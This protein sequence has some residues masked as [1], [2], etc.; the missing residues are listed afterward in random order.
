MTMSASTIL[1]VMCG[2]F[3]L[4]IAISALVGRK[5]GKQ[6]FYN[7]DRKS[8][9]Y[10][11][12]FGMIGATLS[13]VTF[14]SVPGEVG[15]SAFHYLQFVLGNF[16]GYLIIAFMLLPFYYRHNLVSIY[17][18]LQVK[19][20]HQG[21]MTTSG[22]FILSK[23]IGAGFRLYL[24]AIVLQMAIFEQIGMSFEINVMICLLVIW[25]YTYRTGIKA[26]VWSDSLQTIILIFAVGFSI[27]SIF[28]GT[29]MN[30]VEWISCLKKMPQTKVFE[31]DWH[32]PN[33][34]FKQFAAGIFIT[35]AINGFDQ[36]IIQKNLTCRNITQARKNMIWFSLGFVVVVFLFLILGAMLYKYSSL[37]SIAVP[38]QSDQVFPFLAL[39]HLGS[40]M[41]L[42]FVLGVTAAAFSSADSATTALTT[43]FC[44]DFLKIEKK[45][46]FVQKK[47]RTLVHVGFSLLL[48]VIIIVFHDLNN[49]SV[50]N[51]IF[52][53]AGYTY[54]PILGVFAFSFFIERMPIRW[55][56]LPICLFAPV[57]T[58]LIV[59]LLQAK[60]SYQF[61]FEIILLNAFIA[62][63]LLFIFSKCKKC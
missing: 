18:I 23:L 11:V 38:K 13:G 16:V 61:G 47:W 54:G 35:L 27:F 15:N 36:D 4:L 62:F 53:A 24:V 1:S 40:V 51:A 59:A 5:A 42:L 6:A 33:F 56:I 49:Q 31:W 63:S 14:I 7:G 2:Y 8:P 20:G 26:I 30:T 44:I 22:F 60:S 34:F 48:F 9:W 57:F 50:V 19:M 25:L 10:I 12:A 52:K 39:H 32:S 17:S 21:R 41:S 37:L 3:L 29:D 58:W 55:S 46:D 45:S 28:K 43:A